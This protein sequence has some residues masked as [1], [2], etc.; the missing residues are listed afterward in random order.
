MPMFSIYQAKR[1]LARLIK[2]AASGEE[3]IISRR[4]ETSCAPHGFCFTSRQ[5]ET[6][7]AKR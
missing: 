3:I 7:L 2:K 5:T 1:S 4:R 6:G